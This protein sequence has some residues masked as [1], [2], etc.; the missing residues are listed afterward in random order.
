MLFT[1]LPVVPVNASPPQIADRPSSTGSVNDHA[2]DHPLPLPLL[3]VVH[4]SSALPEC[5]TNEVGVG[6]LDAGLAPQNSAA[7]WY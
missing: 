3:P 6:A 4:T 2:T 7:T 1:N 5:S